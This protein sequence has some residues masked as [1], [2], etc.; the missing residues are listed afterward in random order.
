MIGNVGKGTITILKSSIPY[1]ASVTNFD[2]ARGGTDPETL[3]SVKMR[4]PSLLKSNTRAV[5]REDYEYLTLEASSKVAR[6]R[7]ISGGNGAHDLPPGTVRL[8]IVPA[9]DGDGYLTADELQL[10]PALREEVRLYLDERRLLAT[11]LELMTPEYIWVTIKVQVHAKPDVDADKLAS[12]IEEKLRRYINPITGGP[13][14]NGWPFGRNISL[15]DIHASLQGVENIDYIEE[16]Q[17]HTV[18]DGVQQEATTFI[19]IPP[20]AL[21]CSYRHE[22]IVS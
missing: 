19:D 6:V 21:A 9:L 20:D 12:A 3:E 2:A 5:T 13:A 7:C 14:G 8:L 10:L 18:K 16:V 22:I 11:R 1:L 4:A 15:S 17:M